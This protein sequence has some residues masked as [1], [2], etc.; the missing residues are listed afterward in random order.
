MTHLVIAADADWVVEEVSSVLAEPDTAVEWIQDGHLVVPYLA[1]HDD[2]DL[3]I[4]DL[5]V[6]N[7]GGMA[8][9]QDI[10]LEQDS[11]RLGPVPVLMLLDRRPDVFMAR[12]VDAEGWLIKPL[13]PIRL[14]RAG[15]ALLDG[16]TYHDESY[17]PSPR[18][19]APPA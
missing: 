10:R 9:A 2:V 8:I 7:M 5:Q 17:T 19:P 11:E 15:R 14:R 13:D 4:L 3:V 6:S 18:V 16:Q 12:R 1:E